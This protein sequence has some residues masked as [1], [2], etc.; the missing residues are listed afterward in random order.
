MPS[1]SKSKRQ[2]P[3]E[4]QQ[5]MQ[6]KTNW[7]ELPS[8]LMA[9]ILF[10][11]G[12]FDIL[13]NVEKVCT[14][15]RKICKDPS[16]W[17]VI[18]IDYP[19]LRLIEKNLAMCKHAVDRSQGQLIDITIGHFGIYG[20][21]E[22]LLYIA[23]RSSQLRR[24][25]IKTCDTLLCKNWTEALKKFP[26]LEE[27]S[28]YY[29]DISK[30][31]VETVGCC[32]PL[33]KTLKLNKWESRFFGDYVASC[34]KIAIAIGENFHELEHLELTGNQMSNIGLQVILDGCPHLKSLDLRKCRFLDLEGD[35]GKRCSQQIKCL[36]LPN[37]S[38]EGCQNADGYDSDL[39]DD[40]DDE[41]EGYFDYYDGYFDDDD[42]N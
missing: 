9:N 17:R 21:D 42:Y 7:L 27:L 10:R 39:L 8:D 29:Y 3:K 12:V 38:L 5:E 14:G 35:L 32:C 36:K 30:E 20:D 15:W 4:Q 40:S 24:L 37:N 2:K 18:C 19:D 31:V 11:V 23:N 6:L 22:L 13:E 33:L 26:L 41:F 34:D 25:K 28:L 16:M 1:T